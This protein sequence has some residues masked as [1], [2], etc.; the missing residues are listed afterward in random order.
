MR[1]ATAELESLSPYGQSRFYE[2]PKLS[3]ESAADYEERTWRDRLHTD[4]Q[5]HV[6][7]PPMAFKNC[8]SEVA[9]F[10]SVQIPGKGKS[11][12]TK[13]FEAGIIVTEGLTLP[14]KKQE[15]AGTWLFVPADGKRGGGKRVKKCFPVIP[16]WKGAVTFHVLD[17]TITPDIFEQHLKEA[18]NFIGIGFF[19]PRNNGYYGRFRVNTVTWN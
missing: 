19:R 12:Y 11:T 15:V 16:S 4:A 14:I 7:I 3:K 6:V 5:Q 13:H 10:L 9:K 8:L 17:D 18:G 2:T 1:V